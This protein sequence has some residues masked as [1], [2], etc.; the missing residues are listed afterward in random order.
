MKQGLKKIGNSE[1]IEIIECPI[2][3]VL[4]HCR[5]TLHSTT[6]ISPS[7]M[8]MG[9]RIRS[10]SDL[11]RLNLVDQVE[12]KQDTQKKYHGRH[13]KAHALMREIQCL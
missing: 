12:V 11:I 4:F 8:L 13:S 5:I 9:R 2:A 1:S 3:R 7:E 10:H 6:G